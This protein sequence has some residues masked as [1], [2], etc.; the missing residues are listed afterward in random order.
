MKNENE[1]I[2]EIP[3]AEKMEIFAQTN[4]GESF[5]KAKA[6]VAKQS[7]SRCAGVYFAEKNTAGEDLVARELKKINDDFKNK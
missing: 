6:D 7:G 3:L 2:A 1:L 5:N 4:P